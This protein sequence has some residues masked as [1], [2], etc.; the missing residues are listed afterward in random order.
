M[1]GGV[2]EKKVISLPKAQPP[3]DISCA[4]SRVDEMK[5]IIA[6]T[7]QVNNGAVRSFQF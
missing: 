4:D 6:S 5:G 1:W 3:L 7:L 2:T